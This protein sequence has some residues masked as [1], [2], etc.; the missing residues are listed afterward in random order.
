M[1]RIFSYELMRMY[2]EEWPIMCETRREWYVCDQNELDIRIHKE[3]I[4]TKAL[5]VA[6]YIIEYN[7]I[8]VHAHAHR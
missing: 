1:I 3:S 6:Y 5:H 7:M 4:I 2:N 8:L